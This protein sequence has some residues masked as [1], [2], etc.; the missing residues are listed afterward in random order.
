MDWL[1]ALGL[2]VLLFGAILV[3]SGMAI[4]LALLKGA[5][6]NG[7]VLAGTLACG[8]FFM[9]LFGLAQ[10]DSKS[11]NWKEMQAYLQQNLQ[12][13]VT[14]LKAQG[15]PQDKIDENMD[16]AQKFGVEAYPA[17]VVL[18]CLWFSFLAYYTVPILFRKYISRIPR[19]MP[20]RQW[21]IPEPF[22]FGFL[23][24]AMMKIG[25]KYLDAA[26]YGWMEILANNL[27]VFFGCIYIMGGFSI[28]S[29]YL[30]KWNIPLIFRF[31]LY[32]L[33]T[34][35]FEPLFCLGILDVWM[36]LRKIKTPTLEKTA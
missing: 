16:W 31:P 10:L 33:L 25:V 35:L 2:W 11:P 13:Q 8:F 23:I 22:I 17:W 36:D 34:F 26:Q 18:T 3:V 21:V 7:A 20:F 15:I 14:A 12:S 30:Q 27:L 24:G 32:V 6:P 5:R 19:P 29:Y 1:L 28:I 4:L 9:A